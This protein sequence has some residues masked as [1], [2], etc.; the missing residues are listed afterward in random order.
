MGT[1]NAILFLAQA[2]P[3]MIQHLT[4]TANFL[5][6]G[7]ITS[8]CKMSNNG[9]ITPKY[10]QNEYNNCIVKTNNKVVNTSQGN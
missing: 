5:H 7:D 8:F 6:N 2:R 9:D 4:S 1:P 10:T 3:R